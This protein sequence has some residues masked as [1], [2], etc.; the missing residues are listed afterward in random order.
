[1]SWLS[2]LYETYEAVS[3][4]DDVNDSLEPFYH[5]Y[6][7]C[8]IE[9]ILDGEGNF[10]RAE[11][12][13]HEV[14]Y[15][16]Q[17]YWK[18]KETLI[19]I[20][21]KSLTGRT[22]GPAPYPLAE[23]I[24]YVAKDYPDFGGTKESY[25][26][27][28]YEILD[29]WAASQFTHPKIE[30]VRTYVAKGT[31]VQ[32]L[33]YAGIL[34]AYEDDG[35]KILINNWAKQG[36][37]EN[38][39]KKKRAKPPLLNAISGGE[40]GNSKIRWRVQRLGEPNDQTWGD[41]ALIEKW[42]AFSADRNQNNGICQLLGKPS[43]IA[44]SHPKGIIKNINDAKLISVPTDSTYLTFSG[45][46]TESDQACALSFEV[47]QKAHNVLRWLLA[48]QG[49][50]DR[51]QAIVAWAV[52]GKSIPEPTEDIWAALHQE[53]GLP[54]EV[55]ID[56]TLIDHSIDAGQSFALQ[57]NNY[58]RGYSENL[59]PSESI[60]VLALDAATKG[61][62]SVTYYRELMASEFFERLEEWH[63]Q[64]AWP[65]RHTI[66]VPS[67]KEGKKPGSKTIWPVSSPAPRT[68]AEA[69]YG[70]IL[71]SNDTLR[72]NLHERI[73]PC[74]I[75]GRPFPRD[76]LNAA[77]RRASNRNSCE[78]WEWERNLGVACALYRGFYRRHPNNNQRRT[79]AMTL[80][81]SRTTRDYLY[82]RLLA[83]A[84]RTEEM[85]MIIADE[86]PRSTVAGRLM[87]RFADRPFSTWLNIEKGIVPYQERLKNNIAP[88]ADAY[89]RLLDDVCDA[90]E[91]NEFK[92]R[93]SLS[94][95]FLLGFHS[96]RKWFREF[97]LE[98]GQWV[99]KGQDET[100][101]LHND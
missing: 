50:Q 43:F 27:K 53:V 18:G 51:E 38:D 95:E 60:I 61:R 42:Q 12:L 98:K 76:I 62:L 40:Q 67:S 26:E 5:K 3:T 2:K 91:V 16:K 88:L 13:V 32:D 10:V 101:E 97:K 39:S 14:T 28:Y 46:F 89:K 47:S 22:S 72:K 54:T 33:L 94:G 77:V 49:Y 31:V 6:E 24:Q 100:S 86:K 1:M 85:A 74:I 23:Q 79:Y 87:Q 82:G 45:R 15:G 19:P 17:S 56:E 35:N 21:P 20:T 70:D 36:P 30:A 81:Q 37:F 44:D 66:E 96:Q 69:A 25:F 52:S 9:I 41:S 29:S 59:K 71:K 84:E 65:Q 93:E 75:D 8:H 92:S 58:I 64:F 68:I 55:K 83:I 7:Q 34:F 99:R 11:S 57:L 63:T 78:H 80:E 48:R 90:F 4:N 73:L